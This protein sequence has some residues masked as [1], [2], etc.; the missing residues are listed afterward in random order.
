MLS[1]T[2]RPATAGCRTQLEG[3]TSPNVDIEYR[4]HIWPPVSLSRSVTLS[5]NSVAMKC[6]ANLVNRENVRMIQ[7][8]GGARLGFEPA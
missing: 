7:G 5:M 1:I 8:R 4:R 2:R 6:R 3:A